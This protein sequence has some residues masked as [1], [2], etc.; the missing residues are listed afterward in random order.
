MFFKK[1]IIYL[2]RYHAFNDSILVMVLNIFTNLYL[3]NNEII[4]R[5]D[6]I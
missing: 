5:D 2:V 4:K 6:K 1:K 3:K